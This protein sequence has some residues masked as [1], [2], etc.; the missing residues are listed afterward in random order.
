MLFCDSLL[1]NRRIEV[2][3]LRTIARAAAGPADGP[4]IP[5]RGASMDAAR[6]AKGPQVL[7]KL[8]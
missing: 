1:R 6:Q 7:P 4:M 2:Y 8:W 3:K 5:G